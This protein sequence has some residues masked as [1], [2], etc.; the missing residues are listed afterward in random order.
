MLLGEPNE[1][2]TPVGYNKL[3]QLSLLELWL[4]NHDIK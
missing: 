4:Q 1:H 2:R 3:W